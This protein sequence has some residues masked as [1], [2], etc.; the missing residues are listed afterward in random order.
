MKTYTPETELPPSTQLRTALFGNFPKMGSWILLLFGLFSYAPSNVSAQISICCPAI[1]SSP[2]GGDIT[3][4]LK[5]G[6]SVPYVSGQ[7]HNYYSYAVS[8]PYSWTIDG[9]TVASG[10]ST[11][12]AGN[13]ATVAMP[14]SPAR[15]MTQGSHSISFI[16]E[17][18]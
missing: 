14:P 6:D 16:S 4:T 2:F 13:T 17:C 7:I 8:V 9:T 11:V 10:S 1:A 12:Y 5:A 18:V 3:D 15:T